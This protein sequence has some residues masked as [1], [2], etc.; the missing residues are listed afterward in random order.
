MTASSR[1]RAPFDA[2]DVDWVAG[3]RIL[4]T[5]AAGVLGKALAEEA[6]RQGAAVAATGREPAI[7]AASFSEGI[8]VLPA[9]L[10]D[11][12]ECAALIPRAADVLGGLDV[13]VNNAAVLVRR[14]FSDLSLDDFETAWAVNLRAPVLLMQAARAPL[15]R[16]SSAAIV[17]VIS[18]A[19]FN[20]GVDHVAPYAITKAGLVAATKAVAKE[21]GPLGIRVVSLSPPAIESQMRTNISDEVRERVR[22]LSLLGRT[23]DLRE[24][25]LV[26]LFA[27]SPY[28]SF[29]TGATVD[30][31]G[32]VL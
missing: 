27:A 17:N 25:A 31:T 14:D 1:T 6:A 26:T 28:A 29:V 7:G 2:P 10:A 20:G 8:A 19:A 11:P 30:V 16:S 18:T 9:D 5:G 32:I 3:L 23:A 4:V 24:V 15:E 22:S 13:L 12:A 21:Y